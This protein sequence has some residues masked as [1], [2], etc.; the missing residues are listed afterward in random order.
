MAFRA[1]A[2][3]QVVGIAVRLLLLVAATGVRRTWL[4]IA[5]GLLFIGS[6]AF[7][8][9]LLVFGLTVVG[10]MALAEQTPTHTDSIP[11][12]PS[13][14]VLALFAATVVLVVKG[15]LQRPQPA[16]PRDYRLLVEEA[17]NRGNPFRARSFARDWCTR[18][19]LPAEGCLTQAGVALDLKLWG[20]AE[21]IA[22]AVLEQN[23]TEPARHLAQRVLEAARS[24]RA[25]EP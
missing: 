20:E 15:R 24:G 14:L 18:E 2:P 21:R 22:Q 6:L 5:F 25:P 7:Q 3:G 16:A 1:D 4:R 9:L 23:P 19:P 10:A 11:R 13:A 8:G 17:L 12:R